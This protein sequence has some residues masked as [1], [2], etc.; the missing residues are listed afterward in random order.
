MNDLRHVKRCSIVQEEPENVS[1]HL[2]IRIEFSL[3]L[4][5][6]NKQPR[7]KSQI[8]HPNWS[9]TLRIEKYLQITS[10]KLAQMEE[11]S[12]PTSGQQ[13]SKEIVNKRFELINNI[14]TEA[15]SE[16]GCIP[17]KTLKPKAYWCP[18]HI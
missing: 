18:E 8:S 17:P 10:T 7:R 12:I 4:E 16:A 11:F 6:N 15:A 1:D 14:L 2:P 13:N 9:N 5:A 3:P